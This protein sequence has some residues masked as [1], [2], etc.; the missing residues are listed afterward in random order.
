ME[1]LLRQLRHRQANANLH[2]PGAGLRRQRLLR[3]VVAL[4]YGERAGGRR[5]VGVERVLARLLR[6]KRHADAHMQQPL[7]V[8]RWQRLRRGVVA[9]LHRQRP[10]RRR[11]VGLECL[12]GRL[13]RKRDANANMQLAVARVRRRQLHWVVVAILH[14]RMR[15]HP[16]HSGMERLV[17]RHGHGVPRN[18]V[19]PDENEKLPGRLQQR[20]LRREPESKRDRDTSS[21]RLPVGLGSMESL[22]RMQCILRWRHADQKQNENHTRASSVRRHL[23]TTNRN[24]EPILQHP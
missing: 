17:A 7:A 2:Q 18:G 5:L 19:Q 15:P 12:L 6:R 14:R 23:S 9:L 13:R 24:R 1:Q 3:P 20:Q 22:E 8:L 11:L 4:V 10:D 16:M 21:D